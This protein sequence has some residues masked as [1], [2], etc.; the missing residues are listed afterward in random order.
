MDQKMEFFVSILPVPK[1]SFRV[2]GKGRRGFQSHRVIQ[3]EKRLA[4]AAFEAAMDH[5]WKRPPASV[6]I[7]LRFVFRFPHPKS[8]RKSVREK[9]LGRVKRPD[10]DNLLKGAIDGLSRSGIWEDDQQIAAIKA[11]KKD[12]P[13]GAEG[14]EIW[15]ETRYDLIE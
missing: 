8:V 13:R 9:E 11:W 10:L 2:G 1:Q 14:I 5:E 4:G 3:Y 6:P 15:V 7:G 12:V